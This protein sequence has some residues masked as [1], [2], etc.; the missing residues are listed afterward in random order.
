MPR[1]FSIAQAR[2]KLPAL[3]HSVET[4]PPVR[5]TRRGKPVAVLLSVREYDR[6]RPSRPDLW[7]AIEDFRKEADLTAL[8]V[9]EVFRG[10]RDR[11]P[12]REVVL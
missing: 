2:N 7:K 10:I 8:D 9:E 11:S 12:G 3:V 5:L 6:I 4:G 1:D